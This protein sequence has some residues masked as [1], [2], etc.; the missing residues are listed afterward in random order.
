MTIAAVNKLQ[1]I[2]RLR[3]HSPW[4]ISYLTP[5]NMLGPTALTCRF[6]SFLKKQVS[7]CD[8][9]SPT[10]TSIDTVQTIHGAKRWYKTC[11]WPFLFDAFSVNP[12]VSSGFGSEDLLDLRRKMKERRKLWK[13]PSRSVRNSRSSYKLSFTPWNS[14]GSHKECRGHQS[15]RCSYKLFE[16]HLILLIEERPFHSYPLQQKDRC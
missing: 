14:E 4:K 15:S 8:F 9:T 16:W 2:T 6:L 3:R 13:K 7:R 11:E 12:V 1:Q 5:I 10:F